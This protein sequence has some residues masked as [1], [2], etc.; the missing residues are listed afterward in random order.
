[1]TSL[2]FITG[3][4]TNGPAVIPGRPVDRLAG[5]DAATSAVDFDQRKT[6]AE[7]NRVAL[8]YARNPLPV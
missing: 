3:V 1:V 6:L 7:R 2:M 5:G 8:S 4:L